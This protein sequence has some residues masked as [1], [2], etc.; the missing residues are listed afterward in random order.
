MRRSSTAL[1]V[2]LAA[3]ALA[4]GACGDDDEDEDGGAAPQTAGQTLTLAADPGGA[5]K[6]DKDTLDADAGTVTITLANPSEVPH[7]I[8]VEGNGVEEVGETVT[9]GGS[10]TVTVDLEAG[11]YEY[12]CPVGNHKQ[13]GM[14]GKLTVK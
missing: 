6:F 14:E 3:G 2:V 13:E 8:E 4:I 10:S 12:Y 1:A 7:A 11:T 9:K 5:S